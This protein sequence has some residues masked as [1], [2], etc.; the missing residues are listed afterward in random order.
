MNTYNPYNNRLNNNILNDIVTDNNASNA[1]S[2]NFM[3]RLNKLSLFGRNYERSVHS[4]M[5]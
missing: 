5:H 2:G 3:S 4:I 1:I